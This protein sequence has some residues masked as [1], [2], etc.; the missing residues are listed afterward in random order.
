MTQ[1]TEVN[2]QAMQALMAGTSY[3]PHSPILKT[4]ADYGMEYEEV[5]L[6]VR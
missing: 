2:E 3:P 6:T 1:H 4:P 5:T